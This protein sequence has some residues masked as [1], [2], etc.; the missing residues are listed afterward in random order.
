ML[1]RASTRGF[2]RWSI[3][4]PFAFPA[5]GQLCTQAGQINI[6]VTNRVFWYKR[7]KFESCQR[8]LPSPC[9]LQRQRGRPTAGKH[10]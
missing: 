1:S 8:G 6:M 4:L 5:G 10:T 2:A 7:F 3:F 9:E